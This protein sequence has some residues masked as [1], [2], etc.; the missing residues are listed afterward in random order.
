[1]CPDFLFFH[2]D[3]ERTKVSIVDP[4]GHHVPD[5]L[6]KL[7]RLAEFAAAYGV[8]FH[9]IESVGACQRQ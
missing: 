2:G 1:M 8:S 4:H 9:R 5:A 6:P 7:R 3:S